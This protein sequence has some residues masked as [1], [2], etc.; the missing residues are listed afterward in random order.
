MTSGGCSP[1][2]SVQSLAL[3]LGYACVVEVVT[4]PGT[5]K[6]SVALRSA[7][8]AADPLG[9][10]CGRLRLERLPAL[11][12]STPHRRTVRRGWGGSLSRRAAG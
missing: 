3:A 6:L 11:A 7:H 2:N 12:A 10:H 1:P 9:R 8:H 4:T 5:G